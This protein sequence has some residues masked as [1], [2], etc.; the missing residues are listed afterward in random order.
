MSIAKNCR[1]WCR[2][3]ALYC[4]GAESCTRRRVSA[5][6]RE[7]RAYPRAFAMTSNPGHK[8]IACF[9]ALRQR[10][11][12]RVK[13]RFNFACV[14]IERAAVI[15]SIHGR[16][17]ILS[18]V[19]LYGPSL[20]L[21][22]CERAESAARTTWFL[23]RSRCCRLRCT[24]NEFDPEQSG[25]QQAVCYISEC[26]AVSTTSTTSSLFRSLPERHW[27]G[28]LALTRLGIPASDLTVLLVSTLRIASLTNMTSNVGRC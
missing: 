16:T 20:L 26:V 9:Q 4:K 1:R 12:Y 15:L 3:L 17:D 6:K 22:P 25:L 7:L 8:H 19:A 11:N 21:V 18:A 10:V 13:P 23:T 27:N 5:H 24:C 2:S 14:P 28:V